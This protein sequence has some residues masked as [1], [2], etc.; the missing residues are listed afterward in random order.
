M[1]EAP[2]AEAEAVEEQFLD[3]AT[4]A[5]TISELEAE[6]VILKEIQFLVSGVKS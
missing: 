4:A 1:D 2:G 6:I 5:Q 3:Q